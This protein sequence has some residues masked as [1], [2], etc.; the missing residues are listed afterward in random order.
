MFCHNHEAI[1]APPPLLGQAA[2]QRESG[3]SPQKSLP[4]K[5][6][7]AVFCAIH[8]ATTLLNDNAVCLSLLQFLGVGSSSQDTWH[9]HTYFP[10]VSVGRR[11]CARA[12]LLRGDG[13]AWSSLLQV[14]VLQKK[15]ARH[16][17]VCIFCGR[18]FC[19][20]RWDGGC[21]AWAAAPLLL[22]W[23]QRKFLCECLDMCITD[24]PP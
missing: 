17:C 8:D 7:A 19:S 15:L 12:G 14:R 6:K 11:R 21:C 23:R 9:F 22:R 2:L 5:N 24:N 18:W 20:S 1:T 13:A 10:C 16:D 3:C 4:E